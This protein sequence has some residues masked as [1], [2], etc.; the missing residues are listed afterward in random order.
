MASITR[1]AACLGDKD[2]QLYMDEAKATVYAMAKKKDVE[3]PHGFYLG[4]VGGGTPMDRN[5]EE[6][7]AIPFD[8]PEGDR[9]WA[10]P[11][12]RRKL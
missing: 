4:S 10:S 8:L 5:E 6:S 3:L 7:R 12:V 9:T 11:D 1:E 2:V